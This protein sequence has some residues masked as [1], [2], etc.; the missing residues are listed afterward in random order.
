MPTIDILLDLTPAECLHHYAG[1]VQWIQARSTDGRLVE[2]PARAL[3]RVVTPEG[4]VGVFRLE[5]S[6]EGRFL[7]I[8]RIGRRQQ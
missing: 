7:S 2:F 5:F 8:H 4:A 3:R 6:G 1:T